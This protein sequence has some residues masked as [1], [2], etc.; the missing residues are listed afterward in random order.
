[1][2]PAPAPET[3]QAAK[4]STGFRNRPHK[5]IALIIGNRVAVAVQERH[6]MLRIVGRNI[7]RRNGVVIRTPRRIRA[8]AGVQLSV[9]DALGRGTVGIAVGLRR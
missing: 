3:I 8:R 4:T 7:A 1:M 5:R 2:I 9:L 6:G